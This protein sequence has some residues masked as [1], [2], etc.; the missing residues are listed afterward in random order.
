[1]KKPRNAVLA[2]VLSLNILVVGCIDVGAD[3]GDERIRIAQLIDYCNEK[4][5]GLERLKENSYLGIF[6]SYDYGLITN[7]QTEKSINLWIIEYYSEKNRMELQNWDSEYYNP[8]FEFM[9][10]ENRTVGKNIV[11]L[12]NEGKDLIKPTI[13]E[14]FY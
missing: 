12:Y 8:A 9:N 1:M 11:V 6:N 7:N 10:K 3:D 13:D 14:Y 2:I 5:F 4:G